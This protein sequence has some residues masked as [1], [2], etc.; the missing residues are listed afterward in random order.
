MLFSIP[1]FSP[2]EYRNAYLAFAFFIFLV[3]FVR[4]FM[5]G[6]FEEKRV[7]LKTKLIPTFSGSKMAPILVKYFPYYNNLNPKLK[8]KFQRRLEAFMEMKEF[9]PRQMDEHEKV[10]VL[11]G[12]T[13]VQLSFGLDTFAFYSF[14]RIL[15]YPDNYYSTIRQVYHQGEVNVPQRL[16]VLSAKHFLSGILDTNDG[17]NLGLHEMAHAMH[18]EAFESGN[19][20]FIKSFGVWEELAI[21]ERERMKE[22]SNHFLRDYAQENIPEM[23][24]VCTENFFERPQ[25]FQQ[26][27]PYLYKQLSVILRQNPV[28]KECPIA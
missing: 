9:I 7:R 6:L 26:E 12:A 5:K 25:L 13:A 14:K 28:N 16:I 21:Q 2:E 8:R 3:L 15:I 4:R 1:E 27:M 20:H 11:I 24:A 10:N 23:F 19:V 22:H 18:I 17:I